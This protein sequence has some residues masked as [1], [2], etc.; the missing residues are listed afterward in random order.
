LIVRLPVW[1]IRAYSRDMKGPS[2]TRQTRSGRVLGPEQRISAMQAARGVT[3]DAAWQ[4]LK[5]Q[6]TGSL[7]VG[8]LADL[9]LLDRDHL[10]GDDNL[11]NFKV[12]KVWIG[13]RCYFQR[14]ADQCS[15]AS[16]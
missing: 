14:G 12:D 11:L 15:E 9:V 10:A 16:P 1:E 4:S 13:G 7:E 2:V 8:N 3:I 6:G 5:E